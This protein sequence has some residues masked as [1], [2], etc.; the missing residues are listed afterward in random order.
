MNIWYI[1]LEKIRWEDFSDDLNICEHKNPANG[2]KSTH[3]MTNG[4]Y[5]Y[6]TQYYMTCIDCMYMYT[7]YIWSRKHG[8]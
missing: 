1:F 8:V 7:V 6:F 5:W 3:K 4:K 2:A